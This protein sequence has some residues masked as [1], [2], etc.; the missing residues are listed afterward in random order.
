MALIAAK[1]G[2]SPLSIRQYTEMILPIMRQYAEVHNRM[3]GSILK[4][5]T[6]HTAV[7]G[8]LQPHMRRNTDIQYTLKATFTCFE[9]NTWLNS[10][11]LRCC[12]VQ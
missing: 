6:T 3:C 12:G 10:N 2:I 8:K 9:G 11:F 5:T 4:V 1:G 7:C